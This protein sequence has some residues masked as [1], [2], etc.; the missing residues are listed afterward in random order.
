[1]AVIQE[2]FCIVHI[3]HVTGI[4]MSVFLA[5]LVVVNG[6]AIELNAASDQYS[7]IVQYR[8]IN[9]KSL[10]GVDLIFRS[11]LFES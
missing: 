10:R 1:M 6:K 3:T 5:M 9:D 2:A 11:R 7:Y 4:M 8:Y